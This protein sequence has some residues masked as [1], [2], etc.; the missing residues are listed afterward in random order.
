MR[1]ILHSVQFLLSS[2][3]VCRLSRKEDHTLSA[4][5]AHGNPPLPIPSSWTARPR[6]LS[7]LGSKFQ[8]RS[9]SVY[10]VMSSFIAHFHLRE[11][12]P[13][14]ACPGGYHLHIY[15]QCLWSRKDSPRLRPP[16]LSICALAQEGNSISSN[17]FLCGWFLCNNCESVPCPDEGITRSSCWCFLL[18]SDH[19]RFSFKSWIENRRR[20]LRF[21]SPLQI[22][23]PMSILGPRYSL[24]YTTQIFFPENFFLSS[25]RCMVQGW[26]SSPLNA[27]HSTSPLTSRAS[28]LCIYRFITSNQIKYEEYN[29]EMYWEV[30]THA[31]F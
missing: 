11:L 4:S 25:R 23:S 18:S 19:H 14:L 3:G 7:K 16:K 6:D 31:S 27:M 15:I 17:Y 28:E 20:V 9:I 5:A 2:H 13:S 30:Y 10:L 12:T 24:C 21:P 29:D 8:Y 26:L 1:L 22:S